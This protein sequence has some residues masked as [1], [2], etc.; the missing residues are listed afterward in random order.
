MKYVYCINP[1]YIKRLKNSSVLKCF[2]CPP[3]HFFPTM[4]NYMGPS[5]KDVRKFLPIFTPL[6][7]CPHVSNFSDPPSLP[8]VRTLK[9]NQHH[10]IIII[11]VNFF[12][13]NCYWKNDYQWFFQWCIQWFV[14]STIEKIFNKFSSIWHFFKILRTSAFAFTPH[15]IIEDR[16]FYVILPF[17][18]LKKF[19][20]R[21]F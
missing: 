5:I 20:T 9:K 6:P 14:S 16:T 18:K 15:W 13:L 8:D 4:Y 17:R 11:F 3:K 10:S 7:P 1:L 2:N 19:T 12:Y 21:K